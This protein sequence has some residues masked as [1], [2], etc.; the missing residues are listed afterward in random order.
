MSSKVLLIENEAQPLARLRKFLKR[1]SIQV[2]R[3]NETESIFNL[4]TTERFT[5]IVIDERVFGERGKRFLENFKNYILP[6]GVELFVITPETADDLGG[7][8]RKL[9]SQ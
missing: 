1:K 7:L 3:P 5:S 6:A 8:Y 2:V 9:S 4:C